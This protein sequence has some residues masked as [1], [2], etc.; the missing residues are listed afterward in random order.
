MPSLEFNSLALIGIQIELEDTLRRFGSGVLAESLDAAFLQRLS[1]R[2]LILALAPLDR[3]ADEGSHAA[4]AAL[5]KLRSSLDN[6][7]TVQMREDQC[8]PLLLRTQPRSVMTSKCRE[9]ILLTGATGFFGPFLLHELLRQ[10]AA[11]VY[12]LVR[13]PGS[14]QAMERIETTLRNARMLTATSY[15]ML[16]D[17]VHPVCGDLSLPQWGLADDEWSKLAHCIGEISTMAHA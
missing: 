13:A 11:K 10:T 17:R 2:E 12:V 15:R 7:V 14:K 5:T 8:R 6:A 4:L 16:S 9:A 3:G 1:I